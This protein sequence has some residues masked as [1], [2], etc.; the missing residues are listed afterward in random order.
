MLAI[1][2]G[3]REISDITVLD[4]STFASYQVNALHCWPLLTP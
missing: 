3:L 1:E 4:G 2:H